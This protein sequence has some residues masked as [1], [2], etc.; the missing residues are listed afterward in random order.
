MKQIRV[1]IAILVAIA[2]LSSVV[3]EDGKKYELS[4]TLT[5]EPGQT[6]TV[7]VVDGLFKVEG[8]AKPEVP[9]IVSSSP[10]WL[11]YDLELAF[12]KLAKSPERVGKGAYLAFAKIDSKEAIVLSSSGKK[13]FIVG[14]PGYED[15]SSMLPANIDPTAKIAIADVDSDGNVDLVVCPKTKGYY[16]LLGPDFSVST[17]SGNIN[18]NPED[19]KS[20]STQSVL[21]MAQCSLSPNQK[22][23]ASGI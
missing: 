8:Q 9:T 3:A 7:S 12:S 5:I 17:K 4:A 20:R 10:E 11:R 6:A 23:L 13:P 1:V 14:L 16:Y 15:M 19:A 18:I 22:N 21:P 2:G